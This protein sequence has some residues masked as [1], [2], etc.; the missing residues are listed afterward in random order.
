MTELPL[1]ASVPIQIAIS[2]VG[3]LFWL[4]LLW[5]SMRREPRRLRNGFLL[6]FA[7]SAC[8]GWLGAAL[9]SFEVGR[10]VGAGLII[11]FGLVSVVGALALPLLLIANGITMIR[12]ESRS[13]GNAL[14]LITGVG[15]VL[16]PFILVLPLLHYDWWILALVALLGAVAVTLGWLFLGF[17]SYS[18]L[19]IWWAR[20]SRGNAVIVLGSQVKGNRVPPLLAGRLTAALEAGHRSGGAESVP[21]LVSGAQGTDETL[22]EGV[23]MAG[24]LRQ[25]NLPDD[26]IIVEDHARTTEQ[27]L[28]LGA[29][30]LAQRGIAPPYLIAT[31]NYHVPRAALE[32]RDLGIAAQA[33]GG[34]TAWYFLPSAYL[35]EFIA[36]LRV[37]RGWVVA[38]LIP[39]VAFAVL[40]AAL[41]Y[42]AAH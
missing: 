22:P 26:R 8:T 41:G 18:L 20:R 13:L 38:S 28:V 10:G 35:R 9:G 33:V 29:A 25:H 14:T 7:I 15:L 2:L 21:V 23:A 12:R 37:R 11:F 39:A 4:G 36:V 16:S 6:L 32:A 27:N 34:R 40:V 42:M 17:L 31:S 19:Y 3:P 1:W 30:L 24:W 5:L